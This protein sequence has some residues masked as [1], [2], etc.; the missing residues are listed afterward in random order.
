MKAVFQCHSGKQAKGLLK[1]CPILTNTPISCPSGLEE[2]I[3]R[4]DYGNANTNYSDKMVVP[5]DL[6]DFVCNSRTNN[7]HWE[8]DSS[9][10]PDFCTKQKMMLM[11]QESEVTFD[12]PTRPTPEQ[13]W[14]AAS[15]KAE[16]AIAAGKIT[17]AN[18]KDHSHNVDYRTQQQ[19]KHEC[20]SS[21]SR[22]TY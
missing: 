4:F 1:F 6:R 12:C 19:Q 18:G 7:F 21:Q 10:E 17:R 2:V 14:T 9:V 8:L 16:A 13:I 22:F 3:K 11:K 5:Y 20:T 15:E